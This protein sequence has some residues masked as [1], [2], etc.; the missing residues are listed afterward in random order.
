MS[1]AELGIAAAIAAAAVWAASSVMM[2]S[3]LSRV[4]STSV[5]AIR[6]IWA[7]AFFLLLLVAGGSTGELFELGFNNSLQLVAGAIVGLAVG[8]TVY[9]ATLGVLGAGRAFTM[10][11]GLFTVFTFAL[12]AMLLGE[13][14]TVTVVL[15]SALVIGA[16][17]LV[18]LYGSTQRAESPGHH[19]PASSLGDTLRGVAMV[20]FAAVCWAIATVWL[21][22]IAVDS[23]ATVVGA[24][25]IPA[26]ALVVVGLVTL[27][28][29]SVFRRRAIPRKAMLTLAVAGVVGTGLGSLLFIYALQEVGA[30]KTAVISSLSPLFAVPMGAIWLGEKITMWVVL[31]TALAVVGIMLLSL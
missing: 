8:D 23:D 14:V 27:Q 18:S 25:R 4:D 7:S 13:D 9:V 3:Q 5:S 10:S 22:H 17:Y 19:T 20:V 6:L 26:A 1:G 12:S 2:A 16:V 30:G 11:L 31:G 24:I 28:R 21:R 29:N 15:G